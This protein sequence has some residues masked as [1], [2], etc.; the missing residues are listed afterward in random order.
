MDGSEDI[1]IQFARFS[2]WP[3]SL[4][5]THDEMIRGHMEDSGVGREQAERLVDRFIDSITR[6]HFDRVFR[7]VGQE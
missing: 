2:G 3:G 4:E 7:R 6:V 5:L 1:I